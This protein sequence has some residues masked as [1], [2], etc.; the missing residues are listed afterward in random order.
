[1]TVKVTAVNS[2]SFNVSGSVQEVVPAAQAAAKFM[3]FNRVSGFRNWPDGRLA[4]QYVILL[5]ALLYNAR[6]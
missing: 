2:N 3:S 4:S 5:L 6:R 1:M